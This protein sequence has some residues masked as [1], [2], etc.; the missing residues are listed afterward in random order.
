M[1]SGI[2]KSTTKKVSIAFAKKAQLT[3]GVPKSNFE[4][5]VEAFSGELEECQSAFGLWREASEQADQALYLA[6]GRVYQAY[7][8][9]IKNKDAFLEYAKAQD[10]VKSDHRKTVFHYMINLSDLEVSA[11]TCSQYAACLQ[12]A[13]Y[14]N[15]DFDAKAFVDFLEMQGKIAQTAARFRQ[16]DRERTKIRGR[17]SNYEIGQLKAESYP[18]VENVDFTDETTETGLFVILGQRKDGEK[19]TFLPV[20]LNDEKT[21]RA[22]FE[23]LAKKP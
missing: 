4:S 21:V 10:G 19:P 9:V 1:R 13:L 2:S 16:L 20:A 3:A 15:V 6:L 11:S 12:F 23:S 7:A 5:V 14:E 8:H 22:F 18:Y 17:R